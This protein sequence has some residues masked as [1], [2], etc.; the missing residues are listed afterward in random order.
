MTLP[1]RGSLFEQRDD[2]SR[3]RA[4][5]LKRRAARGRAGSEIALSDGPPLMD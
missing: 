2:N 4:R 5:P 3:W 1:I